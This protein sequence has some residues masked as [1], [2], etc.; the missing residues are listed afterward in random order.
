MKKLL[1]IDGFGF[2]V[3]SCSMAISGTFIKE[4]REFGLK[5]SFK[6][7]FKFNMKVLFGT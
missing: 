5:T 4:D 2:V 1:G 6:S 3:N 7:G